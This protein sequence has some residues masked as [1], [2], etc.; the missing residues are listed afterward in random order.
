MLI[1]ST[2][3][4]VVAVLL[5]GMSACQPTSGSGAPTSASGGTRVT[6]QATSEGKERVATIDLDNCNGKANLTREERYTQVIDVTISREVAARLGVSAEVITADVQ[7]AAG[8][9]IGRRAEKS[10]SIQLSAPPGTH[11]TFQVVWIGTEDIGVAQNVHGSDIPIAFQAFTPTDVRIKSQSDIG[12]G[13]KDPVPVV[14]AP[15][16]TQA[17]VAAQGSGPLRTQRNTEIVGSGVLAQGTHS[18]GLAPIGAVE[19]QQHSRIQRIR[20]EECP[21]G[22]DI[23]RFDADQIWFGTSVRTQ[24]AINDQ[25]VGEINAATGKHGYVFNVR[26]RKGD[27]ICV[28]YFGGIIEFGGN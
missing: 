17:P 25:V 8:L 6:I 14:T 3:S 26:I 18:D 28:T 11:M 2:G 22:C 21:Q 7:T 24:L 16:P 5:L 23:A 12:C 1:K 27:K 20:L 15:Q 4:A 19:L 13:V 10:T 9:A